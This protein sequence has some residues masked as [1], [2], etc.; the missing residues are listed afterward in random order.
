[1]QTFPLYL[2]KKS[3]FNEVNDWVPS[4]ILT[5]QYTTKPLSSISCT[6][7]S[8][9]LSVHRCLFMGGEIGTIPQKLNKGIEKWWCDMCVVLD[10]F[11][12]PFK[13]PSIHHSM[14]HNLMSQLL[15]LEIQIFFL[16]YCN[17]AL[18]L[19]QKFLGFLVVSNAIYLL[20]LR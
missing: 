14:V 4:T 7:V 2:D 17:V 16:L 18:N 12:A 5:I 6:R 11:S 13:T 20:F 10:I 19:V 9:S 1:M 3:A 15:N 8:V